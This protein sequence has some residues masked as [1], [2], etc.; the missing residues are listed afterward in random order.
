MISKHL[1]RSEHVVSSRLITDDDERVYRWLLKEQGD[2][3]PTPGEEIPFC[4]GYEKNGEMVAAMM[5]EDYSGTTIWVHLSATYPAREWILEIL[6]FTFVTLECNMVCAWV[7]DDNVKCIKLMK[8]IGAV[9][10]YTLVGGRL[11]GDVL[12]YKLQRD[13]GVH[14]RLKHML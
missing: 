3:V 1:T 13:S 12:L 9:H 5:F 4:I 7:Y 14:T 8:A 2:Q 6:R 11:G 10:E